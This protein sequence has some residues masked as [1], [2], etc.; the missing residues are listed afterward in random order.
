MS[1]SNTDKTKF[2]KILVPI[3]G[4]LSSLNAAKYAINFATTYGSEVILL[5]VV[6]SQIKHG[7]A[8][9]IFGM[10]TPSYLDHY[11]KEAGKWFD[12]I[13]DDVKTQ[14][15]D[16]NKIATD[17]ITTPLSI[18]GAIV[19]Y[20]ERENINIIILGSS[21]KTGFKRMLLGSTASGVVTY[22]HCPVLVVR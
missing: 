16:V 17:V 6:P 20:A 8:S 21:G 12:Q 11:K 5:A 13:I 10:V 7:D 22:A 1:S 3:D 18:V 4:S 19:H 15:Y 2:S 9:G 14:N